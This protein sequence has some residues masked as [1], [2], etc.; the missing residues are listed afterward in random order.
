MPIYNEVISDLKREEGF[1]PTVYKDHLGNPTIGYGF[2]VSSLYLDEDIA[3]ALLFRIVLRLKKEIDRKMPWVSEM[4]DSVQRAIVQMCFQLGV[5]GF[6]SFKRTI[7]ALKE[8]QFKDAE[9][10]MLQSKWAKQTP[11]RAKRVAAMIGELG[12]A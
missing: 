10:Y 6:L 11:E 12:N 3:E 5:N 9:K 7:K 8:N 1:S 2:L 4:P